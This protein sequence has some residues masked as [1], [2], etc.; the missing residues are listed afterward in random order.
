MGLPQHLLGPH[1][2]FSN[3]RGPPGL[4][5]RLV[6][7]WGMTAPRTGFA[8]PRTEAGRTLWWASA[9]FPGGHRGQLP[10]STPRRKAVPA[11]CV[12]GQHCWGRV[13][14][15]GSPG[16]GRQEGPVVLARSLCIFLPGT[17]T[18]TPRSRGSHSVRDP[19]SVLVLQPAAG[20][21]NPTVCQALD[22][23]PWRWISFKL[24]SDAV[25]AL[26]SPHHPEREG[27]LKRA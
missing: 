13:L 1:S 26:P 12:D 23:E 18:G 17:L 14:P 6:S 19:G 7:C 2:P 16:P 20:Q 5:Q 22:P 11:L 24:L 21:T 10:R 9:P 8:E 4:G 15:A 25:F 27:R 3:S